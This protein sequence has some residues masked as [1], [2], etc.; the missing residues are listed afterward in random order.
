M[1]RKILGNQIRKYYWKKDILLI[2]QKQKK[3]FENYKIANTDYQP[4]SEPFLTFSLVKKTAKLTGL[5]AEL[6]VYRGTNA[7]LICK[8]KGK[9]RLL[10]FDTWEGL[11]ANTKYIS[12]PPLHKG[13]IKADLSE[14]KKRLKDYP[15]VEYRKGL[16]QDTLKEFM[17]ET[18]AF[19]YLDLDLYSSTMFAL[20]FLYPRMCKGGII[21]THD[22]NSLK[23]VQ[24]AF[25]EFF[26]NKPEIIHDVNETQ[27]FIQK[28]AKAVAQK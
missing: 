2:S 6:G 4:T 22:Y 13:D 25:G 7:E 17:H 8:A 20:E 24:I 10:L 16:I 11:P 12:Y 21:L 14:V 28:C 23:D 3:H 9:R 26:K 27:A 18:F 19:I 1:I 15:N 5:I